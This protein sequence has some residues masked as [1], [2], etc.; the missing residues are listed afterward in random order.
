MADRKQK[1]RHVVTQPCERKSKKISTKT[2][3][4]QNALTKI[5]ITTKKWVRST[6]L[7]TTFSILRPLQRPLI[8]RRLEEPLLFSID[9]SSEESA[10]ERAG[11]RRFFFLVSPPLVPALLTTQADNVSISCLCRPPHSSHRAAIVEWSNEARHVDISCN[12]LVCVIKSN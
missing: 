5:L 11:S 9:S 4:K 2:Q 3:Q 7:G 10:S 6:R 1:W 12:M 8:V